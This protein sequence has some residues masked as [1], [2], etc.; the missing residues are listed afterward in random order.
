MGTKGKEKRGEA[1]P[2]AVI[3]LVMKVTKVL[4]IHVESAHKNQGHVRGNLLSET[5]SVL[6]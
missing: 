2:P 3:D 4:Y 6:R 1:F 5:Q